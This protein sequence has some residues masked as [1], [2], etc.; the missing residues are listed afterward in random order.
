MG[1]ASAADA[2]PVTVASKPA[3]AASGGRGKA[4]RR[5]RGT[6][7][8][9]YDFRRP[10]KLSRE[11]VR[12]L[13]IV[14]ETFARQY[15]T[16]LTTTLRTVATVNLISIEQATYDEYV[17]TLG[18]PTLMTVLSVDPL[19]G[20]GVLEQSLTSAMSC[21]DTMLGGSGSADQPQRPLSDIESG[22]LR[23]VIDRALNE[24]KFALEPIVRFEPRF[25]QFEYNPQ[26]AQVASAT[27]MVLV[28]S[29]DMHMG[30]VD[31]AFTVCLPFNP[32]LALLEA[33]TSHGTK[34]LRERAAMEIAARDVAARIE[35]VPI[36][37]AVRFSATNVNPGQ[38]ISLEVG[39]VLPLG[40][41]TSY[42]LTVRVGDQIFAY[43]VVGA[44]AKRL[45]VLVVDPPPDEE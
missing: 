28:A 43:A 31:D 39:D 5:T 27:D 22:L 4:N 19:P 8:R 20:A 2:P 30:P 25:S 23:G 33:A 38:L 1:V 3:N 45:A 24:L 41:P 26:F 17:A 34:S 21:I 36:E 15:A 12:T 37:V 6:E 29:F 35:D 9:P 18:N 32:L 42:P 7:P 16:V 14:F 44:Q 10:T 13:Q 11:H 40:H